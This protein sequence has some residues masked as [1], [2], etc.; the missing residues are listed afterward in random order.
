MNQPNIIMVFTDQH[1]GLV[2]HA[3][4]DACAR[5][6]NMDKLAESG[7]MF[8]NAYCNSPLCVPSRSSMLSGLMPHRTK[9][10]NNAQCLPSDKATFVHSLAAAGYE[11]VLSGRMHFNGPDQRHGYEKRFV[12]DITTA[13]LGVTFSKERYG[14][15]DNCAMPGRLSIERSGKGKCAVMAFD[16]DVTDEACRFLRE[17]KDERPLFL[18]VGLY[19]PHP[20]YVGPQELFDYYYENLPDPEPLTPEEFEAAHPFEK[21]FME[22]RRVGHET[23]EEVRRVRA[24]YY[25]MVEYEDSLLGEVIRAAEETLDMDN[26]VVLYASDHGDAIG[27]HGLFWKSNLREGALRVPMIFS[28]RNHSRT[29]C[30]VETPVSLIDLAPTFIELAAAPALP[31]MDGESLVPAILTGQEPE[32]AR[33]VISEVCDIKGDDPAAMIRLGQYKYCRYYGYSERMLFDLERDPAENENLSGRP[34]YAGLERELDERLCAVWDE[35]AI[36]E[37]RLLAERDIAMRRGCAKLQKS[38]LFFDEWRQIGSERN[39]NYLITPGGIC[40]D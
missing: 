31:V 33:A 21:R 37:E 15:F 6:P 18:T 36:Y 40:S 14:Y 32:T 9:I 8:R 38:Q 19:G 22:K 39:K 26:T 29:G 17:R 25:S 23:K 16:R 1:N 34:E 35:Q 27:D 13:A 11:T 2:M 5:T 24:A 20:P 10:F 4:G 30:V 3:M 28:W 7:V 12:G